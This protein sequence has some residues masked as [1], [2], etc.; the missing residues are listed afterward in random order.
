[1]Y[2]HTCRLAGDPQE[3]QM[4]ASIT[5]GGT[6]FCFGRILLAIYFFSE[7]HTVMVLGLGIMCVTMGV[8]LCN[9]LFAHRD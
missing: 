7:A 1:V 8:F 9:D 3:G 5:F 2:R 6:L 4:T